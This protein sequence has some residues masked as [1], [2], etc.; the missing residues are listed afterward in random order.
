[1]PDM[2]NLR[3]T[4]R[5]NGWT[6]SRR[7]ST[8]RKATTRPVTMICGHNF[9]LIGDGLEHCYPSPMYIIDW[10]YAGMAPKYY[11]LADMFQEILV[12]RETE[13]QIVEGVAPATSWRT[14]SIISIFL[15]HSLTFIRFVESDSAQYLNNQIRLL[16]LRQDE[17]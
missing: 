10:E 12:L 1:M 9:I 6:N 11:D 8:S 15:S 3:L 5:S 14:C 13:K 17:I 2:T 7:S 4:R 16:Q